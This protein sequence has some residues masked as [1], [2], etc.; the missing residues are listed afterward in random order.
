MPAPSRPVTDSLPLA[1]ALRVD[2][3]CLRFE[4]AW[5]A[6]PDSG[7]RPALEECLADSPE[8]ERSVLA[9]ELI[10][11]DVC[12]RR[13]KGEAPRAE[14]YAAVFPAGPPHWLAE[15]V[16]PPEEDHFCPPGY[17]FREEVGRTHMGVVSKM[18][19]PAAKRFVALK[20]IRAGRHASR[21]EVERFCSQEIPS[22]AD[23][24][25]PHI[26]PIYEV[27]RHEGQDYFTM[28][29]FEGS[30]AR[31][32]GAFA[33]DHRAAA[34][35]LATVARAVHYAHQRGIIHRDLKPA[36]ILLDGRP[37]ALVVEWA[38]V[39]A[40][41]GLAAR[42]TVHDPVSVPSHT[43]GE[44]IQGNNGLTETHHP[45]GTAAYMAPE[46]AAGEKLRSTAIDVYGLGAILYELL[47][48][49]PPFQG[50]TVTEILEQVKT[51]PPQPPRRLVPRVNRE[52]EAI[53]L[54]CL[55]KEPENRY[56]SALAVAEELERWLG[57]KVVREYPVAW[58]RRLGKWA[59]RRPAVAALV[60]ALGLLAGFGVGAVAWKEA[61]IHRAWH[62]AESQLNINRMRVADGL[63]AVGQFKRAEEILGQCPREFRHWD[64]NYLK[65]LCH[66]VPLP[67]R[68]HTGQVVSVEYSP[69]GRHLATAGRDGTA[70]VWDAAT[71]EL[72]QIFV[73]HAGFVNSACFSSDGRTLITAADDQAV[74]FWETATGRRMKAEPNGGMYVT[75]SRNNHLA[76]SVG[77]S[78]VITLWDTSRRE[79]LWSLPPLKE[80]VTSV[81]LSPDGRY[82]AAAGFQLFK[83]WDTTERREVQPP[84]VLENPGTF[85]NFWAVAFSP[86]GEYLAAGG[87]A[88]HVWEFRTRRCR[89]LYGT[90]GERS[91]RIAF[92][93]HGE[94]VASTYRD[95]MLRVWDRATGKI[96]LSSYEKGQ[97]LGVDFSPDGKRLALTR[98]REVIIE[99]FLPPKVEPCRTLPGPTAE[100]VW[101]LA[102]SPEGR[103]AS[104]AGDR[105]I[106]LWDVDSASAVH[107]WRCPVAIAEET[108]LVFRGNTRLLSGCEG[109]RLQVWD[110]GTGRADGAG[111]PAR[112]ARC[113]AASPDGRWLATADGGNAILLWDLATGQQVR[114]FDHKDSEVRSL[115]FDPGS[116]QLA[117]CG[118]GG[119]VKLWDTATGKELR[120]CRGHSM[121][122]ACVAFS[123]DGRRM[124]SASDDLT[125]RHWD[126]A[127]GTEL[128]TLQG[129]HVGPVA[130]LAFSPDGK[131]LASASIDGTVKLWDAASGQEVLTLKGHEA[132]VTSVAFSPDGGWLATGSLDGRVR[133]WDGRPLE[134]ANA[135]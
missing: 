41:F 70:R 16:A 80:E 94:Y 107:S 2:E 90:G 93:E 58:P 74:M 34:R 69:D 123:P 88:P 92:T 110:P 4:D 73:G 97:N 103:L 44:T 105:T 112:N 101:A 115:A 13:Q 37:D 51:Q 15:A 102:F 28:R 124:A 87:P 126:V 91:S 121:S 72:V 31:H 95:G 63:V 116:Q 111:P 79:K 106:T 39:V 108:N 61:E 42:V 11:L 8:P 113:C 114:A 64:W 104:R 33:A 120:T 122:V 86:N 9:G 1:L 56:P 26:V 19:Q 125:V 78:R 71:G 109:E 7:R 117:S 133:L 25:H 96:V 59:K 18:W 29:W 100:P 12:Y 82:L 135:P 6:E 55:K 60:L 43:P 118:S 32:V 127:S 75:S 14:D 54:K 128:P 23:L 50:A 38:P 5:K 89:P 77:G 36:N 46:Q 52:L 65:R 45:L 57:G 10:R 81:A 17:E 85:R 53:C 129:H 24:E 83:V 48:G 99:S 134:P 84:F 47:T 35:L 21:A 27:G 3:I 68:G 132:P 22:V 130:C 67:L 98:E 131:R 20:T 66:R 49:R 76:A 30:L 40:D 119:T 62:A